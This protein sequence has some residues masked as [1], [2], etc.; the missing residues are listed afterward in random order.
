[1]SY[2]KL[3][4][5]LESMQKSYAAD[6]DDKKIQAAG[7]VADGDEEGDDEFDDDGKPTGKKKPKAKKEEV[8]EEDNPFAK[9]FNGTTADGLEF[10]AIDGTEILKALN[11]RIDVLAS[12][13]ES[14]K[15]EL[16]K[17][18]TFLVGIVKSQGALI[19]SLQDDINAIG[20]QGRG[21]ISQT[22]VN[23]ELAKSLQGSQPL[24]GKGFMLKAHAAF[25]SGRLSGKDLT[26][27]DVSIRTGSTMDQ[28]LVSKVLGE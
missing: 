12:G 5:D 18:L 10:E 2:E 23:A 21:R 26:I 16:S 7:A 19:K 27:C 17:S 28:S 20:N 14:E 4:D 11:D 1:M 9:S 8:S 24:D 3:L 25:D 22:G 15:S 6:E 13:A